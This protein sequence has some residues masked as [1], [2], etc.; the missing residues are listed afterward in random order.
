MNATPDELTDETTTGASPQPDE[1][2]R[3]WLR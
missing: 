3:Y 2:W 1:A